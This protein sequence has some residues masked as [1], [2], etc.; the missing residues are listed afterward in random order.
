LADFK[1]SFIKYLPLTTEDVKGYKEKG[2]EL[3]SIGKGNAFTFAL[4]DPT[5]IYMIALKE[6]EKIPE[7]FLPLTPNGTEQVGLLSA[8]EDMLLGIIVY[9][10]AGKYM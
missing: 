7:E 5:S 4:G 1:V 3:H 9:S 10:T 8:K 2:E 6:G